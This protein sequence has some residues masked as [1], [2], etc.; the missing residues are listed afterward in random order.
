M[1]AA[2]VRS[3]SRIFVGFKSQTCFDAQEWPSYVFVGRGFVPFDL[4]FAHDL[5]VV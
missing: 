3:G 4:R 5:R 2:F 1:R